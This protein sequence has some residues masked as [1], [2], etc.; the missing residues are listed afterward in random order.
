MRSAVA[1]TSGKDLVRI[2]AGSPALVAKVGVFV[3]VTSV[4]RVLAR[5][6]V[7]RGDYTTWSRDESSRT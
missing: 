6:R 1:R 7:R 5:Q 2:A 4:G 3:A